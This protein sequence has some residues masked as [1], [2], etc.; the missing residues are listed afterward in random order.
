MF[1]TKV[2]LNSP[3]HS[4]MPEFAALGTSGFGDLMDLGFRPKTPKP[5]GARACLREHCGEKALSLQR[6][7]LLGVVESEA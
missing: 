3:G 7:I 2:G 4:D 6:S 5:T 1:L